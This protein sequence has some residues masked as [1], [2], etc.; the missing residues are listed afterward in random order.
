MSKIIV[1]KAKVLDLQGLGFFAGERKCLFRLQRERMSN[2]S[3]CYGMNKEEK[4]CT[5]PSPEHG[6]G[7]T[8][9][10]SRVGWKV[11]LHEENQCVLEKMISKERRRQ[12][13]GGGQANG[14]WPSSSQSRD[15]F[16]LR[17]HK[18]SAITALWRGPSIDRRLQDTHDE[19]EK[20]QSPGP[21]TCAECQWSYPLANNPRG[22]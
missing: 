4:R 6:M 17:G 9:A 13:A 7:A 16:Q 5:P 22:S 20:W 21:Q 15:S 11:F 8:Q 10:V 3:L 18:S 1:L 19:P 2:L 14:C 12:R